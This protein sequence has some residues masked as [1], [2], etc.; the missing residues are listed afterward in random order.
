MVVTAVELRSETTLEQFAESVRSG[1]RGD[2]RPDAPLF[3]I[4]AFERKQLGDLDA[5]SIA[6]RLQS[7][8]ESCMSDRVE[9][10]A[11]ASS[12]PGNPIGFRVRYQMCDWEARR[13]S[14][15]RARALDTFRIVTRPV[16]YYTQFVH[17][18]DGIIVKAPGKVSPEA[19]VRAA[20]AI[21]LMT[22]AIR[23]DI[24]ACLPRA[25][26][27]MAIYPK[28]EYVVALPEFAYLKGKT[29][30]TGT[31]FE[32]FTGGVGA[33]KVQPVSATPEGGLLYFNE[34]W[35]LPSTT[36]HEFA[37]AVMNLC[38]TRRDSDEWSALYAAALKANVFPGTYAMT[39]KYEFFA[40]MSVAYFSAGYGGL[41]IHP[42]RIQDHVR[43][44]LPEMFAFLER[45]Y[46]EA[47]APPAPVTFRRVANRDGKY[48]Y[49][50]ELPDG[51]NEERKSRYVSDTAGRVSII[52][53]E[54]RSAI[55]LEQ[56][57]ESV[58]D[59]LRGETRPDASLFEI[60]SFK[61]IRL[62]DVD[63]YSIAYRTQDRPE[64]SI[65]DAVEIVVVA[66]SL[67]GAPVGFR[68]RHWI[69]EYEAA[70][71]YYGEF[72]ARSLASFRVFEK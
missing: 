59:G 32:T 19:L 9:L 38:F 56:F 45:I 28:G 16:E 50:I 22:L 51:L 34:F 46:G 4:T 33:V 11:M 61:R 17:T 29:T 27:A 6:Y 47:P 60:D 58:R 64:H 3:E 41:K 39:N 31:P 1:L 24:R 71:T 53:A 55:T 8:H 63:A 20:D 69:Y 44:T 2:W 30:K 54:L 7:S 5:Y 25:G 37:H 52:V 49:S 36:M 10:V 15:V 43:M 40:E 66:S 57:A 21:S 42:S 23:N 35:P 62:G 68:V 14:D 48:A 26:A 18:E 65:S 72:R 67:H 13:F 12:L 70:Q